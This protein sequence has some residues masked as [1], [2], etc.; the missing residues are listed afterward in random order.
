[1]YT[2][3]LPV[4][5]Y[6]ADLSEIDVQIAVAPGWN[7]TT[8]WPSVGDKH[9]KVSGFDRLTRNTIAIGRFHAEEFKAGAFA[10]RLALLGEVGESADLVRTTFSSIF[11]FY[12]EL[13]K[14]DEAAQ[15]MIAMIPGPND[16]EAYFDSF[17]AATPE[18]PDENN[19]LVWANLLAHEF[20][21]YWNGKRFTTSFENSAERQWFSEGGT[22]YIANQALRETGLMDEQSYLQVMARYLSMHLIFTANPRFDGI[23]L[24]K[25]GEAKWANRPGVYDSGAAAAYCLDGLIQHH[26]DGSR[27]FA[28]MLRLL[29]ERFGNT[30]TLYQF[31]DLIDAASEVAGADMTAFFDAHISGDEPL[32]VVECARMMGNSALV[33]GY[34]VHLR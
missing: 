17:A 27:S 24:R 32:P 12:R 33:D 18:P 5:V 19:L 2:T 1:L 34:H 8:A 20:G 21:H 31:D 16:G 22:E 14:P 25:A 23:S 3:G 30:T 11:E 26:S 4:F 9:F 6:S 28:D 29:N 10:M 15:F 7:V 13:Y